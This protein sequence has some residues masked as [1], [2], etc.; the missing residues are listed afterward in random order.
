MIKKLPFL[1]QKLIKSPIFFLIILTIVVFVLYGK[2]INYELLTLDDNVSIKANINFVSNIKNLPKLFIKDCYYNNADS[3]NIISYYRPILTLSFAIEVLLFGENSRVFHTT[4]I[5]LFILSIYLMYVFLIKLNFDKNIISF[6]LILISVNPILTSNVVYVSTRAECFLTIF[7]I[8]MLLN[9]QKYF[10]NGKKNNLFLATLCFLLSLFSKESAIVSLLIIPVFLYSV[11][12]FNYKKILIVYIHFSIII[13]FYFFLRNC[14]VSGIPVKNYFYNFNAIFTNIIFGFISFTDKLINP[15][16]IPI[17]FF[18]HI[19]NILSILKC[20]IFII[21]LIFIYCKNF[22]NRKFFLLGVSIFI[23]YL[24]PSFFIFQNQLFFHRLLLPLLGL[25]II[26]ILL[27]Q[28]ILCLYPISKKI[29]LFSFVLLFIL[30]FYKAF[31]Q[32]DKY[33]N[34]MIFTLS[35]YQD[36]PTYHVFLGNIGNL[37]LSNKDYDKALE[38]KLLAD[39]YRPGMYLSDIASILC[40]QGKF[41]EAEGLLNKSLEKGENKE[42]SYANLSLI[43]EEKQ[44]YQKSLE[45]AEKAYKENPYNVDISVNLARK[46]ILNEDFQKAL[47]IYLNLL[48]LNNKKAGYYYSIGFLYDKLGNKEKA[49]EFVKK[50]V[51]LDINNSKYKQFLLKLSND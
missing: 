42:V 40:Y 15:Y 47:D 22:I 36:A 29:F 2:S 1:L 19:P 32:S 39:K 11:N 20:V 16:Y 38:F 13:L 31:L 27:I 33:R 14:A 51:Q 44:N 3:K 41:D 12:K 30:F 5:I 26:F 50:S 48:K 23:L 49:L 24:L 34:D 18:D 25:I 46:Y 7:T 4:N 35:G 45:Y 8:L 17:V 28:K 43:Y 9:I 37:Y 21:V 10:D 6:I